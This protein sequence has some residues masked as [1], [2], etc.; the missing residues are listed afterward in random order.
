M[1]DLE[2]AVRTSSELA[3]PEEMAEC[4]HRLVPAHRQQAASDEGRI[5]SSSPR[6]RAAGPRTQTLRVPT[7]PGSP[8]EGQDLAE[9]RE[10][11]CVLFQRR[12]TN[13]KPP[14]DKAK[15]LYILADRSP[16]LP[17][18]QTSSH[19]ELIPM[20]GHLL[21]L[22][23]GLN[24]LMIAREVPLRL[25]KTAV[26]SQLEGGCLAVSPFSYLWG[27]T[28]VPSLPPPNFLSFPSPSPQ[29]PSLKAT[30]QQVNCEQAS[31]QPVLPQR[32]TSVAGPEATQAG[33]GPTH[34]GP[35]WGVC[36]IRA[37]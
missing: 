25:A 10:G 32:N 30:G 7:V 1:P 14:S 20:A 12:Q 19:R 2:N 27:V 29:G 28:C 35:A 8:T 9:Q 24:L 23:S 34:T 16:M 31:L 3:R 37:C 4:S 21:P 22:A 11:G 26:R 13:S 6:A 15:G 36:G 33:R 18:V 17:G 5:H